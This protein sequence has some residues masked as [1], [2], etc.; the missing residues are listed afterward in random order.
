MLHAFLAGQGQPVEERS[1][2]QD[3]VG[4]EGQGLQHVGA[5]AHTRVEQDRRPVADGLGDRPQRVEGS[6]RTVDLPAPV[7]RDDDAVDAVVEGEP[8]VVDGHDALQDDRAAPVVAQEREVRPA[9]SGVG[10][11]LEVPK[12]G[13][14]RNLTGGGP[15]RT[16]T[17]PPVPWQG[18]PPLT[19]LGASCR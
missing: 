2:D 17:Q 18:G 3:G 9:Q 15:T 14:G 11:H 7:V 1:A 19:R 12:F 16:G 5:C 10:E 13:I 8:G 6:H 4:S